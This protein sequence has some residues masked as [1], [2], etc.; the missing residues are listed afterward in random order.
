MQYALC[1]Y[2]VMS[3]AGEKNY[4][5]LQPVKLEVQDVAKTS[6]WSHMVYYLI[7]PTVAPLPLI[8]KITRLSKNT[9]NKEVYLIISKFQSKLENNIGKI[10]LGNMVESPV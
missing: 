2:C 1:T 5:N 4:W 7:F 9:F 6:K 3:Q 8:P 10:L